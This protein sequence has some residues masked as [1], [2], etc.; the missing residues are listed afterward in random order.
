MGEVLHIWTLTIKEYPKIIVVDYDEWSR[1]AV[2]AMLRLLI[3]NPSSFQNADPAWEHVEANWD[4]DILVSNVQM[5]GMGGFELLI[6]VKH[7]F[8][9]L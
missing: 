3:C 9:G 5:E 8:P 1:G 6:R 4:I 7:E 2:V